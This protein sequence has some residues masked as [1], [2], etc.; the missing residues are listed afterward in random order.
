MKDKIRNI[1]IRETSSDLALIQE[2]LENSV[3]DMIPDGLVE[4]VF[5]AM[6][7]IKGSGPMFG[8]KHLSDVA[9]PVEKVFK[10]LY[11]G[12]G[13]ASRQLVE[14]TSDIVNL[15]QKALMECD[16]HTPNSNE[17]KALIEYFSNVCPFNAGSDD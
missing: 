7:T 16:A 15:L 13:Q 9:L 8:F 12:E 10:E 2:E 1:F 17:E 5:R 11:N 3:K 14:K 6:H 4:K